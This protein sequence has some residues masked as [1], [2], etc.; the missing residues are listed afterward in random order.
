MTKGIINIYKFIINGKKLLWQPLDSNIKRYQEIRKL[1]TCQGEDY[2]TG[3]LFDSDYIRYHY[4]LIAVDL[5]QKELDAY[6]KAIQQT[7][8]VEQSK[9]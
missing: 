9:I 4:R 8:F 6:P 5:W 1:A 3:C 7:L 2:T